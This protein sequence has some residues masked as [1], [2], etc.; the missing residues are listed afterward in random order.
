MVAV[1]EAEE[2]A[3]VVGAVED[4]EA[5][6]AAYALAPLLFLTLVAVAADE[7]DWRALALAWM[8]TLPLL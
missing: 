3:G 5:A 8:R 1:V 4:E 2:V 6:L 7:E